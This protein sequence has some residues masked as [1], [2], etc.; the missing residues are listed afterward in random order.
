MSYVPIPAWFH[1]FGGAHLQAAPLLATLVAALLAPLALAQDK[2]ATATAR[3][4]SLERKPRLGDF[5]QMLERRA[6][7]VLLPYS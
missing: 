5:D 3:Q 1:S 4:F 7:R 6:I 2:P